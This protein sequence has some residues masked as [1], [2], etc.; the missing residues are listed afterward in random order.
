MKHMEKPKPITQT[1]YIK[2]ERFFGIYYTWILIDFI[3]KKKLKKKKRHV[4]R[5]F[6][7]KNK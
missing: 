1:G 7:F 2:S 5:A 4:P 3:D 6:I